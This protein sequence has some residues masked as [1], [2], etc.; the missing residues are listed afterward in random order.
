MKTTISA[1]TVLRAWD[2]DTDLIEPGHRID[3]RQVGL[4]N[5]HPWDVLRVGLQGWGD[6]NAIIRVWDGSAEFGRD[7]LA[8]LQTTHQ[9]NHT[10]MRHDLFV[11]AGHVGYR[12]SC[13]D[14][15]YCGLGIS[16][17]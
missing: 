9:C 11:A 15:V 8:T 17:R 10:P 4:L 6:H 2:P 7:M 3:P 5:K 1:A 12:C 13:G 14:T 16:P